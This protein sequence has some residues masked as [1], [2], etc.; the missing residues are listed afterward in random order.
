MKEELNAGEATAE[1]L[2]E[3][4]QE[5]RLLRERMETLETENSTLK[6]AMDD[7]ETMMRKAGWLKALT[8][9]P[10]EV[11]D[12]LQRDQG[13]SF[14]SGFGNTSNAISKSQS[15]ELHEWQEMEKTMPSSTTPSNIKYR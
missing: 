14:T 8:P 7:P 10:E 4:V 2:K 6:K 9:M 1:L 3:M 15:D 13:D 11:Y 12:P 5:M